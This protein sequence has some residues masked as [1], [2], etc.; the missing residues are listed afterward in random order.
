[1]SILVLLIPAFT[2]CRRHSKCSSGRL[3]WGHITT[4]DYS[5]DV[6]FISNPP[7]SILQVPL[8][9]FFGGILLLIS[10]IFLSNLFPFLPDSFILS[11][12]SL[13]CSFQFFHFPLKSFPVPFRFFHSRLS[14]P[15]MFLSISF[16]FSFKSFSI[17]FQFLSLFP[18]IPL[19]CLYD[20]F[21]KFFHFPGQILSRSFQIL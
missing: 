20:S 11:C 17:P 16:I 5:F 6:E 7:I 1:M 19:I 2:L 21:H 12:P 10:F 4:H 9:N 14:V 15:I 8:G 13:L 3:F 18:R